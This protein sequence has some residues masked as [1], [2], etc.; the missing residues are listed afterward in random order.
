MPPI[1]AGKLA[2]YR[3]RNFLDRRLPAPRLAAGA[4]ADV[5]PPR[6]DNWLGHARGIHERLEKVW[7][8]MVTSNGRAPETG[9]ELDMAHELP[10]Q[11]GHEPG[12]ESG[13]RLPGARRE[14]AAG[15]AR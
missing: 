7:S 4:F 3:D 15:P 9:P 8:E 14:P 5:P 2:Y 1:R 6:S 11:P 13:G 12:H 10:G